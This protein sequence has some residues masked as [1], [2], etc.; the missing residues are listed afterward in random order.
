MGTPV[1]II[2][3]SCIAADALLAGVEFPHRRQFGQS[4]LFGAAV[5]IHYLLV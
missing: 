3:S 4:R 2:R 1:K 5:G